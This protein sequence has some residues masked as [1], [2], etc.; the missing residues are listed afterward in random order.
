MFVCTVSLVHF[1]WY[2]VYWVQKMGD[3]RRKASNSIIHFTI[4]S[5]RN[6]QW[7]NNAFHNN[8]VKQNKNGFCQNNFKCIG[9]LFSPHVVNFAVGQL[10]S[11]SP[12][13]STEPIL[14]NWLST[15][16]FEKLLISFFVH[17]FSTPSKWKKKRFLC[18]NKNKNNNMHI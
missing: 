12:F 4:P 8:R 13:I 14:S 1:Q 2:C 18:L 15:N 11:F 16:I 10:H 5:E 6:L 17:I 3:T 7:Q 9:L